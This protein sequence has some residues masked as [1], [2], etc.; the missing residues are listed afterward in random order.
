MSV[1]SL[2]EFFFAPKIALRG[3]INAYFLIAL[4]SAFICHH[5][6]LVLP[7]IW[8]CFISKFIHHCFVHLDSIAL[9]F[10]LEKPEEIRQLRQSHYLL[11]SIVE[12]ADDLLAT[13]TTCIMLASLMWFIPIIAGAL[14]I[15]SS[16]FGSMLIIM[17]FC[18][19][20][21]HASYPHHYSRKCI[22]NL[23]QLSISSHSYESSLE[24]KIRFPISFY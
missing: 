18:S 1:A 6:T 2:L 13:T 5:P 19:Y 24:V 22:N 21:N 9:T 16:V 14:F 8:I 3:F 20:I 10:D 23:I 17:T 4:N 12:H 7:V 15:H 11:D